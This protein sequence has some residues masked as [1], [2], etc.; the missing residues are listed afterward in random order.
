MNWLVVWTPLKNISQLGWL[1][2]IYGNIIQMA[3]KPPTR[4]WVWELTGLSMLSPQSLRQLPRIRGLYAVTFNPS[5]MC[6]FSHAYA[7][8]RKILPS[9]NC[10]VYQR[11]QMSISLYLLIYSCNM[12]MPKNLGYNMLQPQRTC[13][14]MKTQ[15]YG[16]LP[17]ING[18]KWL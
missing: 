6:W 13:S 5:D 4:F 7:V 11:F 3:T 16:H 8:Q 17:V 9:L 18:Y 12:A 2:L 14:L 15:S 1:F 10:S